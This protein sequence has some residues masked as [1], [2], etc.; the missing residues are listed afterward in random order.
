MRKINKIVEYTLL[1]R[2]TKEE[3]TTLLL[4]KFR[5]NRD[6]VGAVVDGERRLL[7]V[8]DEYWKNG[9]NYLIVS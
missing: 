6:E 7:Y 1:D 3:I 5:S 8:H 4:N 9:K 2:D